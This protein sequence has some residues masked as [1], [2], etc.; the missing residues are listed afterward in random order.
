MKIRKDENEVTEELKRKK[1]QKKTGYIKNGS[2][3]QVRTPFAFLSNPPFY[4]P[5]HS[6]GSVMLA[7][8]T[9]RQNCVIVRRTSYHRVPSL[10]SGSS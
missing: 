10:L 6:G 5:H 8:S 2:S 1:K 3:N 7:A 4:H 9:A